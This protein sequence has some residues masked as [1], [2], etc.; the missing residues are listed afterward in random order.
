VAGSYN[1]SHRLTFAAVGR[2]ADGQNF[3]RLVVVP[4]LPQGAD[5]VRAYANGKSKFTFTATL[6]LRVQKM[7]TWGGRDIAL[8]VESYNVTNLRNEVEEIVVTGPL[9]RMP[10]VTQPPRVIRLTASMTF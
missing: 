3:A 5:I 4:D 7:V 6:D 10:S 9:W 2:Y 8:G 1:A